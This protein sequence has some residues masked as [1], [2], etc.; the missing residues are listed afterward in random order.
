MIA[1]TLLDRAQRVIAER[2][3]ALEARVR[4]GEEV[5]PEYLRTLEVLAL[6]TAQLAPE[7]R[8]ALLSTAEM[9]ARLGVTPKS[10]LRAKSQ[11]RI[12]PAVQ[13]GR[14]VRWRGSELPA[15]R[16]AGRGR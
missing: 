8:G 9:A 4:A 1:T 12:R 10:L 16:A 14:L 15:G 6:V 11:G 2:V 7:R 5:W 3:E 13:S